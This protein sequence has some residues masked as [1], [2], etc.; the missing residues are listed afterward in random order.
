MCHQVP[1]YGTFHRPRSLA[2]QPCEGSPTCLRRSMSVCETL[3]THSRGRTIFTPPAADWCAR[4]ISRSSVHPTASMAAVDATTPDAKLDLKADSVTRKQLIRRFWRA[5]AR[6]LA[7]GRRPPRLDPDR[8]APRHH[9]RQLF[10]QYQMNVWNRSLFDALEQKN[11]AGG[12]A[13][14]ADLRAAA[15][16][17]ACSSPSSTST[18]KMTMQRLWREWLTN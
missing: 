2:A 8:R 3:L 10:F 11:A 13:S 17:P 4:A 12:A 15:G 9:P 5:R 14:G 16:R 18:C 7:A 1:R 6:L